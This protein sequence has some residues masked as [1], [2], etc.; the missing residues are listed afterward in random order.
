MILDYELIQNPRK[1][2]GRDGEA[3]WRLRDLGWNGHRD[4]GHTREAKHKPDGCLNEDVGRRLRFDAVQNAK[5]LDCPYLRPAT[6]EDIEQVCNAFPV[7]EEALR[8]LLALP[9][10]TPP[11]PVAVDMA[12]KH[13]SGPALRLDYHMIAFV[14]TSVPDPEAWVIE[15]VACKDS[16]LTYCPGL[17]NG[18]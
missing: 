1:I 9:D 3:Q 10:K 14:S 13:A 15:T 18:C 2:K 4:W 16:R 8:S 12:Q 7:E 6:R 11:L 5:D 17:D